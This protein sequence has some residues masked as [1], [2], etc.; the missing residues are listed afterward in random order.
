MSSSTDTDCLIIFP[1]ETF[2]TVAMWAV[3]YLR[4]LPSATV[5]INKKWLFAG[6]SAVCSELISSSL[7]VCALHPISQIS[8]IL[9]DSFSRTWNRVGSSVSLIKMCSQMDSSSGI[10]CTGWSSNKGWQILRKYSEFMYCSLVMFKRAKNII[11]AV[12]R[13]HPAK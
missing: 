10:V 7:K 6:T 5:R 11:I 8:L 4:R 9:L 2:P 13:L 12:Y 1:Y 3:L